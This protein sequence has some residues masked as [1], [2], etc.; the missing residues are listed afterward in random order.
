MPVIKY[1]KLEDFMQD[2]RKKGYEKEITTETMHQLIGREFGINKATRES[3][4]RYLAEFNFIKHKTS[5]I[6]EII[7]DEEEREV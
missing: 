7:R 6:W 2:V 4:L 5:N 1:E 3:I